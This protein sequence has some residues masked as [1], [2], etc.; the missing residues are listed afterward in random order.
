[1][2]DDGR[3]STPRLSLDPTSRPHQHTSPRIKPLLDVLTIYLGCTRRVHVVD[4]LMFHGSTRAAPVINA[5][6]DE[7]TRVMK[8]LLDVEGG[9]CPDES[10]TR[11][12]PDESETTW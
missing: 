5:L 9:G 7:L 10:E 8:A 4:E 3:V 6:L 1:M 12:E 2:T 11:P